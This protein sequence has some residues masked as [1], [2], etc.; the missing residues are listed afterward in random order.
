MMLMHSSPG[1]RSQSVTTIYHDII[2][3]S[4]SF[5]RNGARTCN[6]FV[7]RRA[8]GIKTM[9]QKI[10]LTIF[11]LIFGLSCGSALAEE[12]KEAHESHESHQH[13]HDHYAHMKNPVPMTAQSLAAG[14]KLYEKNCTPCHGISGK[15]GI[16]PDL[17]DEV[18]IHGGSDGEIYHVITEGVSGTAMKGFRKEMPDKMR[19]H[20]VNYL[21]SLRSGNNESR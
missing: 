18:W 7:P 15:G 10:V 21:V 16:G 5:I 13:R 14:K 19:W 3:I 9:N 11:S 12:A 20:L 6:V 8:K 2:S 17:T 1:K 4:L